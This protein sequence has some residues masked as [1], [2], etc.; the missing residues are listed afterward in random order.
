MV[1]EGI[2]RALQCGKCGWPIGL[3][4]C[5]ADD[6]PTIEDWAVVQAFRR[7]CYPECFSPFMLTH[8]P[9]RGPEGHLFMA[10]IEDLT[11]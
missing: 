9:V 10:A 2:D 11:R 1:A 7:E 5:V 4:P 6:Y 3:C 8:I